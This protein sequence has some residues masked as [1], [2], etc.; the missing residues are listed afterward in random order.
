MI[1]LAPY[2]LFAA[3]AIL[4]PV[5][6]HL[7]NKRQG[8]TVKMGSLRW[9]QPSASN[10]WRSIRLH[11]LGL[12]L[13]RCFILILLALA[14]AQLVWVHTPEKLPGKK[15]VFVADELLY[16][17]AIQSIKP[18]IDSLLQRG[19][20]LHQ[21]TSDFGQIP[22]EQWQRISNQP[23]DS[24][25]TKIENY[26]GLLPA[27]AAK[28]KQP[29]DS[30]WLFT[31]D[32]QCFFAGARPDS[33]PQNIRWIP[34]A[35]PEMSTQW[36]QAATQISKDSLQVITGHSTRGG[37]TYKRHRV[38]AA[39]TS[40][41]TE[42]LKLQRQGDTLKAILADNSTSK[43]KIQTEPLQIA[44]L[45]SEAQQPELRYLQA[46]INAIS[47]YTGQPVNVATSGAAAPDTAA[48]WIFW[49][50]PEAVPPPL[51]SRVK[52]RGLQL[53]VQSGATP[54]PVKASFASA[55]TAVTVHQLSVGPLSANNTA[56]WGT[57]TG[58]PLLTV[59]P[60]GRGNIYL[61]RSGFSP[62]WSAL[63]QSAQ[64][65]ELLL[66][67]L[68][69]QPEASRYDMRALDEQQL[70]PAISNVASLATLPQ[71]QP[72]NLLR[73]LVLAAALLFLIERIIAGRRSKV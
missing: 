38:A 22:Q 34:V 72:Q 15:A 45:Y 9:L 19:Y 64:L 29:Q 8:K 44:I 5:A 55:R 69:P 52:E 68:L 27:L 31:S 21:Y 35:L 23:N 50:R 25:L 17:S 56:A 43:V 49:L 13:L 7:W 67:L 51:L 36:L 48:D 6:I 58:E 53:W 59:Q 42:N 26:W 39:A 57:T 73:W 12:L 71:A 63:G 66:P 40:I 41:N 20:I 3:S 62:A 70:K 4:V 16:T 14:L 37:I 30:I 24:A 2:W 46:A 65:P 61:F 33:I 11:E 47:N 28:Y 54:T 1:F 18:S 10:R 32:Q 60:I